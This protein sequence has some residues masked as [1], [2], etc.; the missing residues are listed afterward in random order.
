M[1]RLYRAC[2]TFQGVAGWGGVICQVARRYRKM[3]QGVKTRNIMQGTRASPASH[4][5][6]D[7]IQVIIP[8][9]RGAGLNQSC[10]STLHSAK[11]LSRHRIACRHP[12]YVP[13]WLMLKPKTP[14]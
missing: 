8:T 11:A 2:T 13:E 3:L 5:V 10:D 1:V 7:Q 9:G 14:L 12:I 4:S 6:D